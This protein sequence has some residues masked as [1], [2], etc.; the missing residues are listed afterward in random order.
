MFK[1]GTVPPCPNEAD[2]NGDTSTDIADLTSLV[3]FMF[4]SGSNPAIC[5]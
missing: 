1:G 3:A 4:K 2:V 5:P